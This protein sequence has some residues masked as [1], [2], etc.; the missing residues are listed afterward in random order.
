MTIARREFNTRVRKRSFLIMTLLGP[1]LFG[2]LIVIPALLVSSDVT[3]RHLLVLDNSY[4][5]VGQ[6]KLPGLTLEFVDPEE[7][8][9]DQAMEM[10]ESS[11]HFDGLLII[12]SS[13]QS[14]PDYMIQNAKIYNR[15]AIGIEAQQSVERFLQREATNEKLRQQGVDPAAVASAHS[16]ARVG[17]VDLDDDSEAESA[18]EFKMA[19]GYLFSFFVYIFI[20]LYA[21]QTM[22]GVIEEKTS[23]IVE[24][25]VSSVK[26]TQLMLGKIVGTAAVGFL[27]FSIWVGLTLGI[28]FGL[29]AAGIFDIDASSGTMGLAQQVFNNLAS[30]NGPLMLGGFLFYFI[31]GFLLYASLFAAVGAAVDSET[32]TQQFML[33]LT[34]PLVISFLLATRFMTD[35]GSD[36]AV[37]MSIIPLTSPVTM[38]MRLPFGVPEWQLAVSMLSL[39]LGFLG[40][41]WLAGRIYRIGILSFGKKP[42]Y[43]EIW[44]W[45]RMK[46]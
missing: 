17:V 26:P 7:V 46:P 29:S 39:I 21:V 34:I 2:A 4:L 38:M 37:W 13:S 22:R 23:R 3:E 32:D 24:V 15:G 41:T 20:F 5:L 27:Q 42:T 1:L 10:Y 8:T 40:S 30:F 16:S 19:A 18:L 14:D 45:I 43:R 31:G 44:R 33:P 35:P 11:E 36:L 25:I 28:Y 12:P 6:E 9:S